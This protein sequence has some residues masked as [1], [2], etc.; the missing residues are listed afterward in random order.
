M[1]IRYYAYPLAPKFVPLALQDPRPFA[2]DD[3]F[4]D[5]W[6]TTDDE[7]PEMLYLDKCW[8][9]LQGLTLGEDGEPRVSHR[10]FEGNVTLMDGG[11]TWLPYVKAL[12]PS[13]VD[14]VAR[15]L[16]RIGPPDVDLLVAKYRGPRHDQEQERS[17]ILQFLG[18]AQEFTAQMQGRG[19]GLTY[20][21]G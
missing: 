15:D 2:G 8:G 4:G 21:I 11:C 1:G 18:Q 5:A 6:M 9:P 10:L 17:Y 7:R 16:A 3:P 19:W 14:K 13:D 12:S 20:L